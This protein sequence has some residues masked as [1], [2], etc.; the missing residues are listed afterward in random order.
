M[1]ERIMWNPAI[2]PALAALVELE[3]ERNRAVAVYEAR[4][5]AKALGVSVAWLMEIEE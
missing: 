4:A 3:E 1:I 2:K 5:F